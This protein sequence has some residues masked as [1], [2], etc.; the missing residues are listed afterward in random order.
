MDVLHDDPVGVGLADDLVDVSDRRVRKR[1]GGE[2][3]TA[4]TLTPFPAY[5]VMQQSF[6]GDRALKLVVESLV[7]LTHPAAA[8]EPQDSEAADAVGHHNQNSSAM[9]TP[10]ARSQ[11]GLAGQQTSPP[12]AP[13]RRPEGST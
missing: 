11:I 12:G 2:R 8:N 13:A 6:D 4:Q 5:P 10:G 3:L 1:R 9:T 7:D